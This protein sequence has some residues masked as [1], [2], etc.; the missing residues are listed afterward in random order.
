MT[1][2]ARNI[3]L[4]IGVV[5]TS[6]L[7]LGYLGAGYALLAGPW[8]DASFAI[9][10]V[11]QWFGVSWEVTRFAAL[12]S[13]AAAGLMGLL[14]TATGA[15][16]LRLFRRVSSAEIYFMT[17]FVMS[18][19]VETIRIGLPVFA[20][21]EVPLFWGVVLTRIVLFGRFAGA[22]ALFT[23]G[24]YSAGADYPRIGTVTLLLAT[25]SFLIVY[26]VPVDSERVNA[27]FVHVVGNR[28][29][30]DFL[31]A[32]LSAATIV[33]YL[34]GW[35]RGH[36]EHGGAVAIAVVAVVVGKEL[37]LHVP[38]LLPLLVGVVLVV[39]GTV[40]FVLV[41]RSYFIWY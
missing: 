10:R 7:T 23:A 4:V 41:N 18:L 37:V 8:A 32:F 24:I 6:L 1:L 26:F 14:S 22:L 30:I 28:E 35:S 17:L 13:L 2:A 20:V 21:N 34:I 39:A 19:S 36:R 12:Q 16:S 29:S 38:S 25:L 15:V 11:Q 9:P 40:S 5:I 33:N 31:L 3:V 27:T